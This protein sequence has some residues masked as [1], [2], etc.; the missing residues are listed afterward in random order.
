MKNQTDLPIINIS[1]LNKKNDDNYLRN[2]FVL[3]DTD[4]DLPEIVLNYPT[5]IDAIFFGI[6]VKGYGKLNINLNS[7]EV[8]E[9]SI[10]VL[11]PGT[12]LQC[13]LEEVSDDFLIYF[14]T[15]SD[16]FIK[17]FD[18]TDVFMSLKEAPCFKMEKEEI[19]TL[20]EIYSVLQEKFVHEDYAFHKEVMQYAL[21]SAIYEF[22]SIYK[23]Y[24]LSVPENLS[25]ESEFER[26][27]FNLIFMYYGTERKTQFYADKL[28]L[29]PK[30]LSAKVKALTNKTVNEWIDESVVLKSKALLKSTELTIQEI[31]FSLNFSDASSFGKFFKKYTGM[32]PVEYRK[33][34]F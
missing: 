20:L 27:F 14:L 5:I 21:L 2:N 29:T 22:Y 25:K 28:F 30:Y 24:I 13:N 15:F 33:G 6:C 7:Y 19:K 9:D 3:S 31:S 10:I 11:L 32:T 26:T 12:I 16:E 34:K 23:K 1:I 17:E 18:S 4:T 8:V